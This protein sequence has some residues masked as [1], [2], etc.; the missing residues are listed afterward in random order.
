MKLTKDLFL[1]AFANYFRMQYLKLKRILFASS[2]RTIYLLDRRKAFV[3]SLIFLETGGRIARMFILFNFAKGK[4]DG[5]IKLISH[6]LAK[7]EIFLSVNDRR[8]FEW[9]EQRFYRLAF[10]GLDTQR[11]NCK[12]FLFYTT[13]FHSFQISTGRYYTIDRKLIISNKIVIKREI[14][15]IRGNIG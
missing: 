9:I 8:Y 6:N 12:L 11:T 14:H 4:S 5:G 7:Y 13:L 15:E 3:S 1:L 2:K 10:R